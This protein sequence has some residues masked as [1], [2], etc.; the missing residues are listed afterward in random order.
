MVI[1]TLFVLILTE[2]GSTCP[3]SKK[4][5]SVTDGDHYSKTN[6]TK[7]R[8]VE[9]SLNKITYNTTSAP[10]SQGSL[11]KRGQNNC[12]SERYSEFPLRLS[13]MDVRS[14]VISKL[15]SKCELNKNKTCS[16]RQGKA[17]EASILLKELQATQEC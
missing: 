10:K 2:K 9:P 5:L 16:S 12:K 15:L 4:H 7:Y 1:C 3:L 6:A 14:N 13:P 11:R 17:Q 8:I